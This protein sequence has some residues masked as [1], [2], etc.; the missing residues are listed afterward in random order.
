[1]CGVVVLTGTLVP[2]LA[3]R[4]VSAHDAPG[5]QAEDHLGRLP[6]S[7]LALAGYW[8][9]SSFGPAGGQLAAGLADKA[10][11][12]VVGSFAG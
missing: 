12:V 3:A 5:M 10:G 6:P 1:M 2:R 4:G 9:A 7:Q 8:P 11:R